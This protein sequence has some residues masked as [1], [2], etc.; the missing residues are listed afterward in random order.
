ML[1][2]AGS[3]WFTGAFHE[4]GFADFCDGFGGGWTKVRILD[5]MKDS[6][7]GTYGTIGL[8]SII[9]LKFLALQQLLSITGNSFFLLL[10][11]FLVPHT[12]S[13]FTAMSLIYTHEYIGK[14]DN[15]KAQHIAKNLNTKDF[16][17]AALLTII[18]LLLII[19]LT[20]KPLLIL[21]VIPLYLQKII[22]GGYFNRRIGGYTGDCL[23]AMQ[24]IAELLCYL[25]FI[26]IWKFF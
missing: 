7:L 20:Y 2:I 11:F 21:V 4:D 23:G 10:L 26:V 16:W 13:R 3:V 18:P 1:S 6:R 5:I 19:V 24:Q 12:S 15:S 8:I 14:T 22:M 9:A 17:I 25:S